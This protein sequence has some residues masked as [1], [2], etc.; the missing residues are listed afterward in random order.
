[1][2]TR[3][4]ILR[5]AL[6]LFNERGFNAVSVREVARTLDMSPG[7]LVYHFPTKG[8]LVAALLQQLHELNDRAVAEGASQTGFAGLFGQMLRVFQNDFAYRGLLANYTD[9]VLSHSETAAMEPMLY[10][11]RLRS[12]E[13]VLERL[14][15]SGVLRREVLSHREYVAWAVV[16]AGR[17]WLTDAR[18]HPSG[19]APDRVIAR[20]ALRTLYILGGYFT[21]AAKRDFDAHVAR[22]DHVSSSGI[23]R[24]RS[25]PRRRSTQRLRQR[26]TPD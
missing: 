11:R 14:V 15:G 24:R 7:N 21:D 8:S 3:D 25:S 6:E 23:G 4:R 16:F 26:R 20:Y 18:L 13:I 22:F 19:D 17:N 12:I 9:A 2:E 1:M 10:E 5:T